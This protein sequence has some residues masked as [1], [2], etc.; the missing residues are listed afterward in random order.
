MSIREK[1]I[2]ALDCQCNECS[3]SWLTIEDEKTATCPACESPD[4][5][6]VWQKSEEPQNDEPLSGDALRTWRNNIISQSRLLQAMQKERRV[7][8]AE[9]E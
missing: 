4:W 1:L 7:I 5:N 2:K 6:K 3:H 9:K 8:N